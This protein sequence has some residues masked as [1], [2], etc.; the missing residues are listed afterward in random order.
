[1][2]NVLTIARRASLII[3]A[4]GLMVLLP[5]L[6]SHALEPG[7]KSPEFNV[8]A[9]D[10]H[11]INL[12][13]LNGKKPLYLKF[14]AT[15]CVA[16]LEEMPHFVTVHEHYGSRIEVVAVNVAFNDNLDRIQGVMLEYG[17]K[18]P[19]VFDE[20]GEMWSKFEVLGTPTH[21]VIDVSGTIVHI[22]YTA[23][24]ELDRALSQVYQEVLK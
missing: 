8:T 13:D 5:M 1:M 17:L 11:Q 9:V 10:G 23:K 22:G 19:I 2:S 15:W 16:C 7:R 4:F 24:T 21:I 18:M 12:G 3:V 20:N 14:W 6:D